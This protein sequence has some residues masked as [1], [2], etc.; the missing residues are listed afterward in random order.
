[1]NSAICGP[2]G[3]RGVCSHECIAR[4]AGGKERM[5]GTTEREIRVLRGGVEGGSDRTRS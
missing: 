2:I 5:D 4:D 1:M 3:E